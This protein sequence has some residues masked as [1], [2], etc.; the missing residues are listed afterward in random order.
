MYSSGAPNNDREKPIQTA[1]FVEKCH[2]ETCTYESDPLTRVG[3]AKNSSNTSPSICF[4]NA[5]I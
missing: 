3:R 1:T 2:Q 5:G 4:D